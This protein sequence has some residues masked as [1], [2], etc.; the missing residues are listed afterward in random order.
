MSVVKEF[1]S[2][3]N[4]HSTGFGVYIYSDAIQKIHTE[5]S[6]KK[7]VFA[8]AK[9]KIKSR[10]SARWFQLWRTCVKGWRWF[11]DLS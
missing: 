2:E 6:F 4:V 7:K 3:K 10:I 11:H 5:I 8:I 1:E 9:T